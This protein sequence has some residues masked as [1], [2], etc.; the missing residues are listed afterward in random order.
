M[1]INKNFF[2]IL[3]LVVIFFL[4]MRN[5]ASNKCKFDFGNGGGGYTSHRI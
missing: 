5:G 3:V 2:F 4:I 1:N